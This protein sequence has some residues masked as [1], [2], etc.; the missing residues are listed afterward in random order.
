MGLSRFSGRG[1]RVGRLVEDVDAGELL[2]LEVLE[3]GTAPGGDV[4]EGR[5]VEAEGAH[6]GGGVAAA[7]DRQPVDLGQRLGHRAGA[8]GERRELED[9]HGAVPEDRAGVGQRRREGALG[10]RTDVEPELVVGDRVGGHDRGGASAEN[11]GATTMSVGRISCT[12]DSSARRRYSRHDLDLVLLQQALAD[13]VALGDEEGEDHPAADEQ[14]VGLAEQVVDDAELVGDLG[15]AEHHGVGTLRV[16]GQPAQHLDLGV[17]PGP[18]MA[19]GQ[20]PRHVVHAGLLAVHDAEAVGDEDVGQRGELAGE[21]LALGL[22]LAGLAR[23]E[24]DVLQH[25]DLSVGERR[26]RW[27]GR[28]SPTVSSAK[29]TSAPEQ[30]AEAGR[31]RPQGVRRVGR[32]LGSAEV[33]HHRHP[34]AGLGQPAQGG[35]AGADAPVVGD[36]RHRRAGR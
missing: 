20:Q 1:R 12:P 26:R 29:A 10:V 3:A 15:P 36:A 14:P 33:G 18:P 16:L 19:C 25:R 30:L 31:D 4:A 9:A 24:A 11:S 8:L 6:G 35:Q 23:V 34:G 13:P 17:R 2:A 7:D 27:R 21:R 5:L 32:A 28:S 22:V